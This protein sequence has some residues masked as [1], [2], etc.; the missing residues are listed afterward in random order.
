MSNFPSFSWIHH[1]CQRH[2]HSH[3]C[4]KINEEAQKV[5]IIVKS[6]HKRIQSLCISHRLHEKKWMRENRHKSQHSCFIADFFFFLFLFIS[7]IM[8]QKTKLLGHFCQHLMISAHFIRIVFL[9]L[10]SQSLELPVISLNI[11]ENQTK[12]IM[13]RK[14]FPLKL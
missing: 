5:E 6:K 8:L 9:A 2:H 3:A 4:A 10:K 11:R 13:K 7:S 12:R 14:L 1:H